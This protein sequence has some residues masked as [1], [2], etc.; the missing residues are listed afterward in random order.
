M[1]MLI[2]YFKIGIDINNPKTL[3]VY[4][5][6][7]TDGVSS[8]SIE[9]YVAKIL[10]IFSLFTELFLTVIDWLPPS[11]ELPI[12]YFVGLNDV[13]SLYLGE[14]QIIFYFWTIFKS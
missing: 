6:S 12:R 1:H 14:I 2:I 10:T 3:A 4:T 9:H 5:F 11:S 7:M 8:H 13:C